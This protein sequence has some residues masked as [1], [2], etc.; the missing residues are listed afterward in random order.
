L[1]NPTITATINLTD[2]ASAAIGN[3][4]KQAAAVTNSVNQSMKNMVPSNVMNGAMAGI[5]GAFSGMAE[6]AISQVR[7][8]MTELSELRSRMEAFGGSSREQAKAIIDQ[9]LINGPKLPGG[10]KGFAD[11]SYSAMKANFTDK[12]APIVAREGVLF[13][14]AT[15]LEPAQATEDLVKLAGIWGMLTDKEG[16]RTTADKVEP[17]RLSGILKQVRGRYIMESQKLPGKETDLLEFYKYFGPVAAQLGLS[18]AEQQAWALTQAQGGVGGSHAGVYARGAT[19]RIAAPSSKA[20]GALSSVGLQLDDFVTVD[21]DNLDADAKVKAIKQKLPGL[22]K[23][24]SERIKRAYEKGKSG[25]LSYSQMTDEVAK[26]IESSKKDNGKDLVS[27]DKAAKT[28]NDVSVTSIKNVDVMGLMR[29]LKE[30]GAG[31]PV[32]KAVFG[33]ES[34]T[35]AAIANQNNVSDVSDDLK[36]DHTPSNYE[37]VANQAEAA[38]KESLDA[39]TKRLTESLMAT[40]VRLMQPFEEVMTK[41]ANVISTFTDVIREASEPTRTFMGAMVAL[42]AG[43]VMVS[44]GTQMLRVVGAMMGVATNGNLAAAALGRVAASGAAPM[45]GGV[46]G[47]AGAAG[48]AGLLGTVGWL[49]AGLYLSYLAARAAPTIGENGATR[50]GKGPKKWQ[51]EY[52]DLAPDRISKRFKSV[53]DGERGETRKFIK[54]GLQPLFTD[55]TLANMGITP[56]Q[57]KAAAGWQSSI[58]PVAPVPAGDAKWGPQPA[59]GAAPVNVTGDL[60]GTANITANITLTPSPLFN[61]EINGLKAEVLRLKGNVGG[62]KTGT[63]LAGSN[64]AQPVSTGAGGQ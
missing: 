5:K 12:Q 16:K 8:V 57:G 51:P 62:N 39:A 58:T 56:P 30:I 53:W 33:I 15:K 44:F 1:S 54:E 50:L 10:A 42:G 37:Q 11:A 21:K 22:E 13:A 28:A 63:N 38:M 6:H 36:K 61:A 24:I 48:A 64:G 60:T 19:S 47:K 43:G 9:S 18:P 59:G 46:A 27:K 34:G 40:G 35:G 2:N 52:E 4:A 17:E 3:L 41:A 55:E 20:R 26:A 23:E 31:P 29:R 32:Y 25:E 45:V 14:Q 49:G 7:K